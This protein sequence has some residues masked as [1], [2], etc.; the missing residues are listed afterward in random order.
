MKRKELKEESSEDTFRKNFEKIMKTNFEAFKR[1][2]KAL[3]TVFIESIKN[4]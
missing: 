3:Y 1:N 2:N 4:K